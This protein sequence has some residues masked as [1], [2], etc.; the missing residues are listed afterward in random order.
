[1]ALTCVHSF[2][3]DKDKTILL[4]LCFYRLKVQALVG[5]GGGTRMYRRS[6]GR[7]EWER[8]KAQKLRAPRNGAL[9]GRLRRRLHVKTIINRRSKPYTITTSA[10]KT[11]HRHTIAETGI[12]LS[13][14]P[15]QQRNGMLT[16]LTCRHLYL[17]FTGFTVSHH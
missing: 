7:P 1:M 15:R 2:K 16:L 9:I 6:L 17:P 8:I 14:C 4:C 5:R 3:Y 10:I 11:S 12:T 13:Y